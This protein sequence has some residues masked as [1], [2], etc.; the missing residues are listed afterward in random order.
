MPTLSDVLSAVA[1]VSSDAAVRLE[2]CE[3][4]VDAGLQVLDEAAQTFRCMAEVLGRIALQPA[5]QAEADP[6]VIAR[7][8]PLEAIR[9]R[10]LGLDQDAVCAGE[11]ELF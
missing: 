9:R 5:A 7:G 8:L 3:T 2:A 11:L 4:S 10:I 1:Q 6:D